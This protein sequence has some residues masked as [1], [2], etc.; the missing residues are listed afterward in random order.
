MPDTPHLRFEVVI[1]G[2]GFAGVYAAKALARELGKEAREK[3]ALIAD[4]NFMVFQ[5]MLAEVVGSSISPRH[6]INPLRQ[7]CAGVTTL[8][9]RI[10]SIDLASRCLVLDAGDYTRDIVVEFGHLALGTG[11]IVDLSRVPGMPEHAYVLKN[12]GDALEYRSAIIDRFEEA[13]FQSDPETVRRL[14]TFVIVGG[15]YSGVET[16]GQ[17][18]DLIIGINRLYPRLAQSEYRV[19]LVHSREHLMPEVSESLARYCEKTMRSRGIELLLSQRVQAMTAS[20]VILD[21]GDTI[22]THTVLSTVGNAAHPLIVSLCDQGVANFHQR[23]RTDPHL[24]VIASDRLWA[25]GDCAA[26]PMVGG[27]HED[28]RDEQTCPPTAQFAQREGTLMG[29]NIAHSLRGKDLKPF[30]FTGL[31]ELATIGHRSAVAEIMGLK[32]SGFIAWFMWRTIY[33]AKLP[34]LERKLRVLV[35]WT[36]DL[37]FTR[38]IALMRPRPTQVLQRMHLEKGDKIFES[39]DPAL[40][41]YIVKS[42]RVDLRDENGLVRSL[43]AGEHFGERALLYD[44]VWRF[45]ATATETSEL[46]A[47][48]E[49]VFASIASASPSL[50]AFFEKSAS[51]FI[52]Q[53]E[54]KSLL[55]AMPRGV[56]EKKVGELMQAKPVTMRGEQTLAEALTLIVQHP[57]N[58]FPLVDAKN[59]PSG[60]ISQSDIYNALKSPAITPESLLSEIEPSACGTVRRETTV[61]EAIE[62]FYRSGRNKVLVLDE[63]DALCGI[64]TPIDLMAQAPPQPS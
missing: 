40:S 28:Q 39:G 42:G 19:V 1:A 52:T 47:L 59:Y 10:K 17:V 58:S 7:L 2:G 63:D 60:V 29:Q 11:S 27:G 6:V 51:R 25:A 46:V 13:N 5:P 32:F 30:T 12:V 21:S 44:R 50:H 37:F 36:L 64:L 48:N 24:R 49:E 15:G 9:G 34:G 38:D 18:H 26:V 33:M 53:E 14:L 56:R 4:E 57:Y 16:A 41:L 55:E 22:D 43:G 62:R 35:D 61:P 31:G 8:R 23:L 45:S 3:V 54:T 20:K